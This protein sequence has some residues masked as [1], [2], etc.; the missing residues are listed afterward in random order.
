MKKNEFED[1]VKREYKKIIRELKKAKISEHKMKVL[2]PVIENSA[3][4]RVKLDE[5]R[6]SL[7]KEKIVVKYD[8]GGGQKGLRKNPF[9]DAYEAL[10][11]A[12][13]LGM[14]RILDAIPA[15]KQAELEQELDQIRPISVL[16]MVREKR[17]EEA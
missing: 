13:M 17:R 12:Y 4:M 10:F 11:K 7:M 9:F 6:S 15:E 2:D 14:G 16:D 5:S 1:L 3:W 8:N